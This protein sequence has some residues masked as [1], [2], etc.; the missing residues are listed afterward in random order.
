MPFVFTQHSAHMHTWWVPIQILRALYF[1]SNRFF[2]FGWNECVCVCVLCAITRARS[3]EIIHVR[4]AYIVM[5]LLRLLCQFFISSVLP[6]FDFII[7]IS[8]SFYSRPHITCVTCAPFINIVAYVHE[9]IFINDV[10]VGMRGC[11]DPYWN[12]FYFRKER[13]VN[14]QQATVGLSHN[15]SAHFSFR[16][17]VVWCRCCC[18]CCWPD[19][20]QTMAKMDIMDNNNGFNI[21][22]LQSITFIAACLQSIW[23]KYKK[24]E[25][26]RWPT[27]IFILTCLIWCSIIISAYEYSKSY[28][29]HWQNSPTGR[30]LHL[31]LMLCC[32]ENQ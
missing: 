17:V 28:D 20:G 31:H 15:Q 30:T 10:Y 32:M 24:L 18:Y 14:T 22:L 9:Y 19:L 16:I 11:P 4:C 13:V 25:R 8:S 26:N 21:Y 23:I 1:K 29:D 3:R 2:H 6:F 12:W 27:Q 5:L 7:T